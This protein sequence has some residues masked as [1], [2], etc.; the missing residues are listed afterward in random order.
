MH[1]SSFKKSHFVYHVCFIK[2]K[3]ANK[4][5]YLTYNIFLFPGGDMILINTKM[6]LQGSCN[7]YN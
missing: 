6:V 2:E 7:I 5:L 4:L 3:A 1:D